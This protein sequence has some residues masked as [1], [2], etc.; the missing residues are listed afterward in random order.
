MG[1]LGAVPRLQDGDRALVAIAGA[2]PNMA[3]L[4]V[5]CPFSERCT[6]VEPRC[7][8]TRPALLPVPARPAVLR[9]CLQSAEAVENYAKELSL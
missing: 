6:L 9:A 8:S 2:P 5:G 3:R 1:L 7:S 4:P